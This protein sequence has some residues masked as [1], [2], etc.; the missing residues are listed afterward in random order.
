MKKDMTAG[1]EWRLILLFTLPIMAGNFLQ[2][3]YNTV[4]GIIVG[5]FVGED[6]LSAVGTCAPLTI[7]FLA[8]A[9]GLGVGG[10]IV[11][12]Q[13]FGAKR[14]EDM[15]RNSSTILI[16]MGG[17]GLFITVLALIFTPALLKYILNVPDQLLDLSV[18]YFRIYCAG[19][20]F[21]FIYNSIA[22]MLRAVGDSKATLYFLLVASVLNIGLDL[23]L[24]AVIP[25]GVAGAAVA[26]VISQVACA[27]VSYIYMIKRY[28]ELKP[29][30]SDKLFDRDVCR[31]TL[32]LGLPT[33][34]QQS[35]ISVGHIAMQRL[36]NGFGST[37][38]AAYT[39]AGRTELFGIIPVLS[40]STG[41]ATFTGQNIGA[42]RQDRA[43][44]GL[45]K[46]QIM[47]F[48]SCMVI[49]ILL[50][51]FA[52]PVMRLFSL[53]GESMSRGM[54]Q[55]RFIAPWYTVFSVH[56]VIG[57]FLQGS[58]D[59]MAPSVATL[60]S[61]LVRIFIGYLMVYLGAATYNGAWIAV[62]YGFTLA[63]LINVLRFFSGKW[64]TK[65]ITGE[66]VA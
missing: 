46:T 37:S 32:R 27:G 55:I 9:I 30:G 15:S 16:L 56:V 21:Q 64:K 23:L 7:L 13:Y 20:F 63:L 29:G 47:S 51:F 57:G 35:I 11:I 4:D 38:I 33:A 40:F 49:I 48:S 31:L 43:K 8:L 65:A 60:S 45:V 34:V 17:V 24:V 26:T 36:V 6:A 52:E 39:A 19:L 18:L 25:L 41:L 42:G 44:R 1:S 5:N 58:G 12:S 28:P 3:L 62:P 14:Y 61:L 2:Q 54:E 10:G 59:V 50:Y 66:E 22:A 53:E